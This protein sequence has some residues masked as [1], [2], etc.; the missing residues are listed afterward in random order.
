MSIG[1]L[2]KETSYRSEYDP[3]L[4]FGISRDE[5]RRL[6]LQEKELPFVGVDIW[7]GYEISWLD[8]KGKPVRGVMTAI[9][10]FDSPRIVESKSFKLY[11]NSLNQYKLKD[12]DACRDLVW[13]D[14]SQCVGTDKLTLYFL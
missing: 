1:P 12:I 7:N 11:L 8:E 9:V 6:L 5:N 2:G 10:P 13:K 4:L 3:T 14:V